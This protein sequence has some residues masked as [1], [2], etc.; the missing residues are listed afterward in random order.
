MDASLVEKTKCSA[1][2]ALYMRSF[3]GSLN[4]KIVVFIIEM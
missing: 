4:D 1:Q 2:G 3:T